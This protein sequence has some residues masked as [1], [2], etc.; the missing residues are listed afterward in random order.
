MTETASARLTRRIYPLDPRELTE[1]ELAVVFAM[2]SRR[3]E[4][5]DE[6]QR[7]VT[8]EKAAN[9]HERW[10]LGYGH[11]SVAEHAV[12]HLAVENISRLACDALEDN[13]LASFTE[14]W[15]G[16]TLLMS[17]KLRTSVAFP[18]A[19]RSARCPAPLL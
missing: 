18:L 14:K 9:F 3:P 12:L 16:R 6:T 13:R 17:R 15:M 7:L 10:V 5:F 19:C 4:P 2:T 8:T 11:A 1:E